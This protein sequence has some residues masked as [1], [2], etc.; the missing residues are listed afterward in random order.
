MKIA[1]S[2]LRDVLPDLPASVDGRD[3][4]DRLVRVGFEVESV[5][6][7]GSV[8]GPVMIGEVVGFESEP[9]KNG[10]TI[11]WC[12]V[13]VGPAAEP[14][15]IVC[16]ASN[17]AVGDRVVV[18]LPGAVL[19]GGF[20]ISA[21]KTYG[22]VSDGM[23]CSV[24]ELGIGD[25][26]D[27]ILVLPPSTPLGVDAAEVLGFG[28]EVLDVGPTPDRGYGMSVRGVAREVA[29]AYGLTFADPADGFALSPAEPAWPVTIADPTGCDRF[30]AIALR[31]LDPSRPAPDWI[32]RRLQVAGIRSISLAVD[33]T[34]YVML[35]LGQPLHAYDL[36][37]LQGPIVVRRAVSGE[38]LRTLDDVERALSV[39][40]LVIAD[41]SGAIG[42]AGVMGGATT[43]IGPSTSQVLLEAAHFTPSVISRGARR[44]A[45][46]S[47]ASR[48]FERGVDPGVAAAAALRAAAL[49]VEFGGATLVEA[50]TDAGQPVEPTVLRISADLPSRVVGVD[51]SDDD[52]VESLREVGCGVEW[53]GSDLIVT[54]PSWRHD[55]RDPYDLVE[56]VARLVGYEKIPSVLPLPPASAGLT[57]HQR[58]LRRV[59]RALADTGHV[60]APSYPFI[61]PADLD[62]LGLA[63]D[64]PR[65]RTVRLANPI[66]DEQ[67]A[68]RTT[69]LPGLL[70]TLRRNLSRGNSDLALFEIGLVFRIDG[71]GPAAEPGAIDELP[72]APRLPVDRRPTDEQLHAL[73]AALPRQPRRLA[74]VL[75]GE[76]ERSG[77]WGAGRSTSWEDA[78][79]AVRIVAREAGADVD[80]RADDDHPP[81]HPGRCAA[82]RLGGPSGVLVGH[83]GE[84]HPRVVEALGLP[85][86]TC[87][88]E[89][90]LDAVIEA[91]DLSSFAPPLSTYPPAISDLA[92]VVPVGVAAADVESALRA[93][94]GPLLESLRLFDV[95]TG[96]GVQSGHRSLAYR[97]SLRSADHTLTAEEANAVRDAA[98]AEAGRRVG[99][100]LRA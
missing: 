32:R 50:I 95:Y 65:R 26:H 4:A 6:P 70:A 94:A 60:E 89:L 63:A 56:E 18:A 57:G 40:D 75:A 42:L 97:L 55:L 61:G 15:G 36:E 59:G 84:L 88:A 14:R 78:L 34:N 8:I 49:L 2:W 21:R 25:E 71:R 22:H 3:V 48:R 29:T 9:Q 31:G 74:V 33:V 51:Y 83:A 37:K 66:S 93:G 7:V 11:R 68:L 46:L 62:A 38:K 30:V 67:P 39:D 80:F 28:D 43:E 58:A 44:H 85:A 23:I 45:L 96:V 92:V 5:E 77:W 1:L 86:R 82:L 19:P 90:D 53:A 99:A 12:Q 64:D 17:F 16:G 41:D 27:G 100:T 52:V 47:E 87:A 35:E 20:E 81:W 73:N 98:V 69:L 24:R 13:R 76:R 10:K 91:G 54:A 72:P 79:D